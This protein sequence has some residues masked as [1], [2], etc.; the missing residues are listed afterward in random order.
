[1]LGDD[2]LEAARKSQTFSLWPELLIRV[3]TPGAFGKF[4]GS[5]VDFPSMEANLNK[6][7]K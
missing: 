4:L 6:G 2:F 5:S 7:P 1:M 3:I